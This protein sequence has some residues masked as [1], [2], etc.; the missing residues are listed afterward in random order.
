ME[1]WAQSLDWKLTLTGDTGDC[2]NLG[3]ADAGTPG[4]G[5]TF[6]PP[7]YRS[8][9]DSP[10]RGTGFRRLELL[11]EGDAEG[12]GGLTAAIAGGRVD[13]VARKPV[14]VS[15]GSSR[16]GCPASG[17][18]CSFYGY[19]RDLRILDLK[20][21]KFRVPVAVGTELPPSHLHLWKPDPVALETAAASRFRLQQ[22]ANGQL[23]GSRR[24]R[25]D[26]D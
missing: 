10:C 8:M 11:D 5:F 13:G 6:S 23:A 21:F 7:S 18:E 4:S 2:R 22:P 14:N 12:G 19:I 24:R 3:E 26:S 16:R 15:P 20:W 25:R 1:G 9:G 17:E